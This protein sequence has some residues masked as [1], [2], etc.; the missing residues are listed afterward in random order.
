MSQE[1]YRRSEQLY[2]KALEVIVGGVNSP[3]RSFK[4]VGGGAPVFAERGQGA[5]LWDVDG[6]RYIDYLGAYGPLILGHAHPEMTAAIAQA[7]PRG[8]LYGVP[9]GLEVE[10]AERIR[11]AMPGMERVRFVNSG[12]EAV[13][14][15][16]RLARAATGR[17]RVIK[18]EGCY[19]GH[20]DIALVKAG[21][22]PSTLGIA[23]SA[24]VPKHVAADVISLPFNDLEA[25]EAALDRWGSE[26]AAV[27]VEPIVGNM[28]IVA[29]EPG[30][31]DG[32]T[33]LVH[34][35]GALVIYDEVITGFR[36]TYG[37][38]QDLLG[39][40][41]DLT[42]LGKI[43]G[44]GLALGAYGG[45]RDL[46]DLM[47]PKG[48]TYQAGTLAG[49]PLSVSA[50][51][52]ALEIL[53]RPGT[54]EGLEEMSRYLADGVLSLARE[55]GHTVQLNRWGSGFTLFFTD[56]PVRNYT[57]AQTADPQLFARMFR[58]LLDRGVH[59]A[60][61]RFEAWFL[62]IAHRRSDL[63]ATLEAAREVF[64]DMRVS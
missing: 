23:D 14:T 39:Q 19:H 59:L 60:P 63:D 10:L 61:S 42:C 3:A 11:Q 38:A 47:A 30:Y 2:Q 24:G 37:G 41:P 35:A 49:N 17:D 18:F 26:V 51:L 32:V 57:A 36:F 34:G 45:R 20:S 8:T 22:G 13:M 55:A 21:S 53:K 56:I 29:P 1:R 7:A 28:G 9:T 12:T 44:G 62:S 31:L 4:A 52:K 15:A 54:Y 27:L 33:R 40:K 43:I 64:H 48:S 16:V 25:L 58:G 5:Y 50:G 6:N 46:M